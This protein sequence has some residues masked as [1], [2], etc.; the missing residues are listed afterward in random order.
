MQNW[1]AFK[2][3]TPSS[4]VWSRNLSAI[5]CTID[6]TL[7]S[8]SWSRAVG[9]DFAACGG[10]ACRAQQRAGYRERYAAAARW[11]GAASVAA[12]KLGTSAASICPCTLCTPYSQWKNADGRASLYLSKFV[13]PTASRL[14]L[15]FCR[16]TLSRQRPYPDGRAVTGSFQC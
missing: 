7:R 11:S 1:R 16:S 5:R 10:S 9:A 4:R 6:S 3:S 15:Y 12:A 2:G 13:R 8:W 14:C